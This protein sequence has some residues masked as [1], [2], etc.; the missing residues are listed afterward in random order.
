LTPSLVAGAATLCAPTGDSCFTTTGKSGNRIWRIAGRKVWRKKCGEL[1]G[2]SE[3]IAGGIE[4]RYAE[5]GK[6]NSAEFGTLEKIQNAGRGNSGRREI[7][8]FK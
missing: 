6:L 7:E 1:F 5:T 2:G 4:R 3:L 8:L